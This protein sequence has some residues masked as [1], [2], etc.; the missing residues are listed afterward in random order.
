MNGPKER[1]LAVHILVAPHVVVLGPDEEY[2]APSCQCYKNT[3]SNAVVRLIL[4]SIYLQM[5]VRDTNPV[6]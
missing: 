2:Q 3:I 1:P 5:P 6:K 4:L